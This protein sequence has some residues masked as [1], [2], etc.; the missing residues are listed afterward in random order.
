MFSRAK[1]L[2]GDSVD[3]SQ[4]VYWAGLRPMTP[5][6]IPIVDR[7]PID[8]LWLNTGHGHMGWTMANG[9][10][11]ILADLIGQRVPEHSTE[12]LRYESL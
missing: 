11:Q 6:G 1:A 12:G 7:S 9:C 3:Y 8:N 10:A 5:T 2:F 4:P